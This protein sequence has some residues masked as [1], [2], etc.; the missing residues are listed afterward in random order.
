MGVVI[1]NDDR[2]VLL[3]EDLSAD[4]YKKM[5]HSPTIVEESHAYENAFGVARMQVYH[6]DGISLVCCNA[7]TY[8]NIHIL[9]DQIE[10]RVGMLF[11]EQGHIVTSVEGVCKK[12][13]FSS[14][15]HNL[16]FSPH[17]FE[18]AAVKKQRDINFFGLSFST[19]RFLELA[20]NNG[21]VLDKLANRVAGNKPVS[22]NEKFNLPMTIQMQRVIA[23]I[24][25]C[26]FKGPIKKL[27]LQSKALELLALQCDQLENNVLMEEVPVG[28]LSAQDLE[29]LYHARD[30]MIMNMQEPFTLAQLSRKVG[31]NEF[32]LKSGFKAV[33]NNTVYGYLNDHR[34]ETAR[35]MILVGKY[36]MSEIAETAG[37]SSPQHFS[38]AFKK[39]YGV[40]P[41]QIRK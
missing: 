30:L 20:D 11:M 38:T 40:S 2:D 15:E 32:K 29:K 33:F 16:L 17:E 24:K 10:P 41:I 25:R 34:L 13:S 21:R 18:S 26:P 28:K 4:Y 8:E 35:E 9:A 27:F 3:T 5:M 39:K 14:L 37:Y 22:L 31:L 6:F 7:D 1:T 23:D 12:H 36:N 19:D